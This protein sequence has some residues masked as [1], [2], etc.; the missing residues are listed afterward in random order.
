MLRKH[1]TG[2]SL[3]ELSVALVI[4]GLMIG[5][6]TVGQS[7]IK[8]AELRTITTEFSKWQSAVNTFRQKYS[9]Y[10]GDFDEATSVWGAEASCPP[11][12]GSTLTETCDGNGDGQI[13]QHD[14]FDELY[15][16]FLFWQHLAKAGLIEGTYSGSRG[17]AG[18][19]KHIAGVNAPMS[20]YPGAG[21]AAESNGD[22]A[23]AHYNLDTH[24]SFVFGA[25]GS[26][27]AMYNPV[28]TAEDAW[29]VDQKIDDGRPGAGNVIAIWWGFCDTAT[30]IND[31]EGVYKANE[32]GIRCALYFRNGI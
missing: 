2:Y 1:Q 26:D 11:A 27:E 32:D 30:S 18:P 9:Q 22:H 12:A 14:D 8:A 16:S 17:G 5:G 28:L 21:W 19:W 15:E 13:S 4:V 6:I 24:N 20:E 23:D 25:D 10:P 3:V 7:L 31:F 29:N